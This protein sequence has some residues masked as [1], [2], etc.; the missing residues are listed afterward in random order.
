MGPGSRLFVVKGDAQG[1]GVK[2]PEHQAETFSLVSSKRLK[3]CQK[4]T[5]FLPR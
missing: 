5:H 4:G 1:L 3:E 2:M